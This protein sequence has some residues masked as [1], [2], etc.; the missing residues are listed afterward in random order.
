MKRIEAVIRRYELKRFSQCAER[1]GVFG[2]DLSESRNSSD[3]IVK[4]ESRNQ[5][6]LTVDF[7]VFD[8]DTKNIVHAVLEQTHPDSI[9]IF[10]LGQ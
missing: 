6:R 9:S 2:F 10:Q 5:S 3:P 8:E 1:L 4:F 7:A